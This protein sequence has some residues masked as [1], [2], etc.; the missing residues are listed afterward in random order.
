MESMSSGTVH[1]GQNIKRLRDILGVKQEVIAMGLHVSQQAM[2]K[3]EQKEQI[4]RETLEKI[5][6]ILHVPVEAIKNFN[7]EAAIHLM[8]TDFNE[9]FPNYSFNPVDKVIELYE[10]LLKAEKEKNALLEQL[11]A[12][13]K[14]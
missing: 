2:S 7:D 5:S 9:V 3:L 13:Q 10:R 14:R 6:T 8:S 4:D 11:I 1:H 12:A